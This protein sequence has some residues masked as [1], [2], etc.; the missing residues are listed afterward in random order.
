MLSGILK[1]L[2]ERHDCP[3]TFKKHYDPCHLSRTP[4]RMISDEVE[5]HI[6]RKWPNPQRAEHRA[7]LCVNLAKFYQP[8]E[9]SARMTH[10]RILFRG[11][12]LAQ[13]LSTLAAKPATHDQGVWEKR[14][15]GSEDVHLDNTISV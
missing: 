15:L 2:H 4:V 8:S 13:K 9:A 3:Q 12:I 10:K 6:L 14:S 5:K 1:T 11:V 7:E